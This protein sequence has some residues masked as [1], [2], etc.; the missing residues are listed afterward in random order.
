LPPNCLTPPF[1]KGGG[2]LGGGLAEL[3]I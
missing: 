2:V 3:I 1:A